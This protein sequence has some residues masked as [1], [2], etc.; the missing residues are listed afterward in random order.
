MSQ[1]ISALFDLKG[2]GAIVTGGATGIGKAISLRL[3]E[4]GAAVMIAD[5]DMETAT[6]TVKQINATGGRAEALY[7]DASSA[8][9]AVKVVRATVE[10]FGS[11]DILINNAGIY[12]VT[13]LDEITEAVWDKVFDINVR[14]VFFYSQAVARQMIMARR[15]GKIVN[16]ASMESLHP[17]TGLVHYCTSKASVDMLTRSLALELAPHNILVNSVAPGGVITPGTLAQAAAY[18]SSSK[19]ATSDTFET[20]IARIPLG[21]IGKPD[22]VAGAVLFLASAAADYM[23][24]SS[25]LIDGGYLLS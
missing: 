7:A 25:I 10:A 15:G 14:G 9:D 18:Q 2:K 13:P 8:T 4:A 21:R 11:V 19:P 12:P 20:Y 3:A 23:T 22:D 5:I 24:G 16:I 1:P 17:R 6:L